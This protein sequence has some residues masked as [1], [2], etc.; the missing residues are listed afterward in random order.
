MNIKIYADGADIDQMVAALDNDLIQGF[1][2]NPTLMR[3]AGISSYFDFATAVLSQVQDLPISFE[4]FSDDFDEMYAQAKKLDALGSNVFVKIPVTNT[5]GEFAGDL[6]R[7]L[8][9]EGVKL[10]ITA[11]FTTQQVSNILRNISSNTPHIISVF[12]GRIADTGVDPIPLMEVAR[13][14]IK[15]HNANLQLLWASPREVLNV[16]QANDM[17]CDIITITPALIKK[18][19]LKGKSLSDFSRETVQMF[20]D[21]ATASGYTL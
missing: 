5:R 6:I 2:T 14:L 21:D 9:E 10:N 4:V 20:Y 19:N 1:T 11:V 13:T 15:Q 18:L 3:K 8:D 7:R 12:A 17:K 16:Y